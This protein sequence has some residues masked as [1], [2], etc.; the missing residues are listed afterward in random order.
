MSILKQWITNKTDRPFYVRKTFFL[1]DVPEEGQAWVCG[2]GQF[3]FYVNGK[4]V[5]DRVLD[6]AWTDYRK[7]VYYVKLDITKYLSKGKNVL[8]AE[9]G[10]GWYLA[11]S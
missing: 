10:N 1:D 5:S 6:P 7:L 4:K 8:A 11:D 3:N 9:V 2:L